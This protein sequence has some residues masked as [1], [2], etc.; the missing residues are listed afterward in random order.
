MG[1]TVQAVSIYGFYG[2]AGMPQL[3]K[4]RKADESMQATIACTCI[5]ES[6]MGAWGWRSPGLCFLGGDGGC[7]QLKQ[8]LVVDEQPTM[9]TLDTT[10]TT[11]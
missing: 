3:G 11:T 5:P 6:G 7:V 10:T 9:A 1:G 2:Q 4:G 8:S